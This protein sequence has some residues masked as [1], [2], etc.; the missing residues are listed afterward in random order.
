MTSGYRLL[1]STRLNKIPQY[2]CVILFLP[3]LLVFPSSIF[4]FP[5][6]PFSFLS[7]LQLAFRSLLTSDT[8]N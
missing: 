7:V 4:P 3:L 6:L 2:T 8:D 5:S 1:R